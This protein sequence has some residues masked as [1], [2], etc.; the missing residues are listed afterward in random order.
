MLGRPR[1]AVAIAERLIELEP[2]NPDNYALLGDAYRALG[3][4][5]VKPLDEE[6]NE[7]GKK[8]ARKM[9]RKMTQAEYDKALLA[10]PGG[11]EQF[12]INSKLALES[13]TKALALDPNNAMAAR[14]IGFLDEAEGLFTDAAVNFK[15]YL[16]LT[17]NAKD[18]R[19]VRQRIQN[20]EK[21]TVNSSTSGAGK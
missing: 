17:P 20:L 5:S 4:R 1:T 6:L 9:L 14:G 19:Q 16:E 13:F 15:K 18:A 2:N 12:D 7:R 10:A 3:A 8:Q 11:K 21:S